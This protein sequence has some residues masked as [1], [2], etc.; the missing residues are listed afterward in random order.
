MSMESYYRNMD[1]DKMLEEFHD[2]V[3][4]WQRSDTLAWPR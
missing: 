3:A 1:N 2:L 4:K